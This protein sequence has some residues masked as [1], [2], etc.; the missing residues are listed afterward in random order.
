MSR[1]YVAFLLDFFQHSTQRYTVIEQVARECYRPLINIINSHPK[2]RFSMSLSNSLA[3]LLVEFDHSDVL[4]GVRAGI[5]SGHIE[6]VHTGAYHPIFPLLPEREVRWQIRLDMEFKARTFGRIRRAGIWSPE[7]CYEDKLIAIYKDLGFQ[8]TAADDCVPYFKRIQVPNDKVLC[9]SDFAVLLRSSMWSEKVRSILKGRDFVEQLASEASNRET[10]CYKLI[11][12]SAETFGHHIKYYEETFIRDMLLTLDSSPAV[13]LCTV[14]DLLQ[15]FPRASLQTST[16]ISFQYLPASSWA[17]D[18]AAYSR[19]DSYP[20]WKSNGNCIHDALWSLTNLI[21]TAAEPID[22]DGDTNSSLRQ[23]LDRAFYSTQYYWASVWFFD[24]KLIFEG[25]RLQMRALYKCA[26]VTH[27]PEL[28]DR[29]AKIYAL[30]MR[31][32]AKEEHRRGLRQA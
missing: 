7:M 11:S 23:M 29:G 10:D 27:N 12:L 13:E 25:L 6:L 19:G 4:A 9:V 26:E 14:S 2:A 32:I 18:A 8:W 31:E 22:F 17:T 3:D 21:L 16:D 28:I 20:H 15:H 1:T 24:P 5:E 30:L